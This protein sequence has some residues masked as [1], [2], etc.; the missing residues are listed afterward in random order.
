MTGK[1]RGAPS[2]YKSEYCNLVVEEMEQ[3][4]SL[5]AFAA[6]IGVCRS[7]ISNWMDEHDD[8]L[9]AVK[10]GMAKCAAWWEA[11]C[12]QIAMGGD[13]NPTSV[14]FGL[15][16]MAPDDWREKITQEH[17]GPNGTA[18]QVNFVKAPNGRDTGSV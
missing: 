3:G 6:E 16:N 14:I 15:K 5:T 12:R 18:L 1:T 9:V 4:K 7:T 10:K 11:R 13:G 17:T 8:F 2:K